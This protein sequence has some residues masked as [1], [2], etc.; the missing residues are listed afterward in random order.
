MAEKVI[1]T[2]KRQ[3]IIE[4]AQRGK[5]IDGRGLEDFR[6]IS[7]EIGVI[8]K[9]DGSAMVRLGSTTILTG[10]K[11]EIGEPFADTPNEGV[12]S[13][14]AEFLPLASP[15]FEPGPPDENALELARVVDRV[16]RESGMV[17]LEKMCLIPGE[18]VWITWVDIYVLDHDGNLMDASALSAVAALLSSTIPD[19]KIEGK[20]VKVLN[21]RKKPPLTNRPT[22][23]T[24]AKIE[25]HLLVDPCLEEEN[26]LDSRLTFGFA[27]D[28]S[29]CAI[30]KGAS[31]YFGVDDVHKAFS[32]AKV[33]SQELRS[34]L[35]SAG[36]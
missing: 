34:K 35:S 6:P 1:S 9:A 16:I 28:G 13:V 17:D 30:Q 5:R 7:I 8:D 21:N 19:T 11:Y 26:V 10:I 24:I 27:Q 12:L 25:K 20:E 29:L 36:L 2:V 4:L 31:G 15:T 32:I 18:K 14:N 33:K 3:Q 23:V 22:L